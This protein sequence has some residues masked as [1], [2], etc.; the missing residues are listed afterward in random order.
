MRMSVIF[1]LYIVLISLTVFGRVAYVVHDRTFEQIDPTAAFNGT[2]MELAA[3]S[4]ARNGFIGQ[5]YGHSSGKSAHVAPLYVLLLAG[6][7]W[8]FGWNTSA[9]RL[10]QEVCAIIATTLGI[11]L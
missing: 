4:L 6:L 9:G 1:Y 11:A 3:T 7:Y 8:I 10:A 2:E 5:L